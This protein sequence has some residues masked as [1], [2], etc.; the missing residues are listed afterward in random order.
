ML[1]SKINSGIRKT[2]NTLL[3]AL[4]SLSNLTLLSVTFFFVYSWFF[5]ENGFAYIP[6]KYF[7][8][9]IIFVLLFRQDYLLLVKSKKQL[10]F[11]NLLGI[12]YNSIILFGA[13][14]VQ[15]ILK[16]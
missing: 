8:V 6:Y 15:F 9:L 13:F 7:G 11:Y 3:L 4:L 2:T 1:K 10:V 12:V 5:Y 14:I 16:F